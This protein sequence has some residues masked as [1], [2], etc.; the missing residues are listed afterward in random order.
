VIQLHNR[1]FFGSPTPQDTIYGPN[2]AEFESPTANHY[3]V[4][5]SPRC[6]SY[7]NLGAR[8]INIFHILYSN[9]SSVARYK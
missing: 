2:D 9:G 7:I 5:S 6:I 1:A 4:V 8:S 3:P